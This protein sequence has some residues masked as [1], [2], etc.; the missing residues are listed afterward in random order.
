MSVVNRMWEGGGQLYLRWD[1]GNLSRILTERTTNW[2]ISD[3]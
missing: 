3:R 1:S 2:L